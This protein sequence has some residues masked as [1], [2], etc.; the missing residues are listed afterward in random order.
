MAT[1]T[2]D[3]ENNIVAHTAV[4]DHLDSA[5]AFDSEKEL[6][7]L[8]AEWPVARLLDLWN[9]FAGVAPFQELKPV[10]KFTNRSVAVA[11]IWAAIQ[12]LLPA[13][14]S[15]AN[16]VAPRKGEAPKLAKK[17]SRRAPARTGAAK[18][19]SNKKAEVVAMMKRP[20]GATLA[21]IMQVTG[22]QAHTVRGFV[23][24]LASKGGER[25]ESSKNVAGQRTYRIPK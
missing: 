3:S 5:Q 19:R 12:R 24:I 16:D 13:R 14:A 2:I 21:E 25:V 23:S 11:R 7:K 6:A 15:Q 4:P 10:K 22:W 20:K 9:S 18:E 1:F 17:G 8:V